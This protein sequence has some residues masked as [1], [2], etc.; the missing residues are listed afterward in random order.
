[1][2][3]I[4]TFEAQFEAQMALKNL[5]PQKKFRRSYKTNR[6]YTEDQDL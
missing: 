1:M 4:N 6:V 2:Q 3:K 5:E